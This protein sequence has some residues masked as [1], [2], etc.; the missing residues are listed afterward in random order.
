MAPAL[1][2]CGLADRR[3]RAGR[4]QSTALRMNRHCNSFGALDTLRVGDRSY[5]YFRLSA[6]EDAGVAKL[7]RLPFSLKILLENFC[8]SKTARSSSATTSKRWR[9]RRMRGKNA[10]SRSL[11]PAC[12][13][14]I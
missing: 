1:R 7:D 2:R 13:S 9:A 14:K 4:P 5:Q 12:C 6:L 10:K 8:D 3:L 11:P